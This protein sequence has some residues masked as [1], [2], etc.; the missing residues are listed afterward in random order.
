MTRTGVWRPN[1]RGFTLVELLVV[2]GIIAI[3]IGVLLPAL[4]KARQSASSVACQANLRQI[5]QAIVIYSTQS[6]GILPP[7]YYDIVP[8]IPPGNITVARWVDIIQGVM[9]TKYGGN[10]TDAFNTNSSAALVRKVF[11]CPEGPNEDMLSGKVFA[12]SYLAHPRLMPQL[13]SPNQP[14]IYPWVNND[15][16]PGITGKH[17]YNLARIKRASEIALIWDAPLVYD[18]TVGG[19]MVSQ[20]CPVANQIDKGRYYSGS[21]TTT[22]FLTDDYSKITDPN[23]NSNSPIDFRVAFNP[24]DNNSDNGFCTQTAR[25]RH[26]KNTVLNALMVD[27]HV[28]SF[29]FNPQ[30]P[31]KSDFLRKNI[32]VNLQR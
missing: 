2:I 10:S 1:S 15:P 18:T 32:N 22:T 17:P 25:F 6:R 12:C 13:A 30:D 4:N 29:H 20:G 27:G 16:Y 24:K 8:P 21:L 5:G 9:A 28:Q 19:W 31:Q 7:G 11:I 26:L 23:F 14:S 3:L